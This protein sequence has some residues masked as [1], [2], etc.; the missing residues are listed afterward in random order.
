MKLSEHFSNAYL[1][2]LDKR[3]D[4]LEKFTAGA[5]QVGLNFIK[6]SADTGNGDAV[7]GCRKS[8]MGIL[9]D[10]QDSDLL[11]LEDDAEFIPNFEEELAKSWECLPDDWDMVYLGANPLQYEKVNDRWLR[12]YQC[13]STHAYILRKKVI[14]DFLAQAEKYNGHVDVAYAQIHARYKVY[15]A[16]PTLVFQSPTY[17]DINESYVDYKHL[18]FRQLG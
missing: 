16:R 10:H 15:I 2:N 4:R 1:I 11:V 13:S 9:K 18:Y 14:P 8:H 12:S 5:K 7:Q 6:V 3:T 17:S